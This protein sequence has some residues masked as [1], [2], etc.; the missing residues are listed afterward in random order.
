M[1]FEAPAGIVNKKPIHESIAIAA[2]I[3]SNLHF[4]FGVTYYNLNQ[5]QWEY[6]RGLVWNDDPSCLLFDDSHGNNHDFGIGL[7]WYNAF[8]NGP[9]NCMTK[10]SHF[11]NLQF[12]HGMA[13]K[14][15]EAAQETKN[16]LMTWLEIMY[17]LACGDQGVLSTDQLTSRLGND[18]N[19]STD[20]AGSATLKDLILATTPSY[21]WI[22]LQRR[23]LGICLHIIQD[24]YAIGHTQRRLLNPQDL[25]PRDPQG[26]SHIPR[27]PNIT[28]STNASPPL[29]S[30]RLHPIPA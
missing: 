22:N 13:T 14:V 25:A 8:L 10:R 4:N 20:P 6:F 15:G 28:P 12:L 19:A 16:K 3:N 26:T 18:F 21:G 2:F 30:H 17:K 24:S 27:P 29:G 5:K 11:G 23:A 7:E 9:P 1:G